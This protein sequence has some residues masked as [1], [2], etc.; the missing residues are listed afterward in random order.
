MLAATASAAAGGAAACRSGA[1][2]GSARSSPESS[3]PAPRRSAEAQGPET[4]AGSLLEKSVRMI[5]FE[6][7]GCGRSTSGTSEANL[8]LETTVEDI[9]RLRRHVGVDK[10]HLIAH[11]AGGWVAL[12]YVRKHPDRVGRLVLIDTSTAFQR[13]VQHRLDYAATIAPQRF[14]ELSEKVRELARRA[15]SSDPGGRLQRFGELYQ[16]LGSARWFRS[17]YYATDKEHED[18]TGGRPSCSSTATGTA[19]TSGTAGRATS[20]ATGPTS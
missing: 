12:E 4:S 14:P 7:R 17:L 9:E 8:R 19:Q 11:S 13:S 2:A 3:K 1:P 18:V 16:L 6:Q 20:R 5:Y 15:R 10:L